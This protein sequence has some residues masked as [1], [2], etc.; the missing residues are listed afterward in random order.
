[1]KTNTVILTV[2]TLLVSVCASAQNRRFEGEYVMTNTVTVDKTIQ[3]LYSWARSGE[4]KMY[5]VQRGGDQ[6]CDETYTGTTSLIL[7]S[8]NMCYVWSKL[9]KKGYKYTYSGFETQVDTLHKDATNTIAAT[10][11]T[12]DIHGFTCKRYK[13]A[14]TEVTDFF[15]AKISTAD[16]MDYWVCEDFPAD[17][18]GSTKVTGMPFAFEEIAKIKLP[19]FGTGTQH[20]TLAISSL[21]ERTVEDSELAV[22]ADVTFETTTDGY[23]AQSQ[24]A[25]EVRKYMKKNKITDANINVKEEGVSQQKGEWDF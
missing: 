19:L 14:I 7:R 25:K 5:F 6:L 16:E 23:N 21:K 1:M 22:P 10:G 17:Y 24:L 4:Y 12:R 3:R 9:T 8:K 11:E 18:I 2:L 15:G 13:G 20:Q